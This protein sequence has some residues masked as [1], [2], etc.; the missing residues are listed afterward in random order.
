MHL[1]LGDRN[2]RLPSDLR[3]SFIDSY[4]HR[5][6]LVKELLKRVSAKKW[7][8][9]RTKFPSTYMDVNIVMSKKKM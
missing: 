8:C 6:V 4:V 5:Q 9:D 7:T 1:F 3:D 2:L